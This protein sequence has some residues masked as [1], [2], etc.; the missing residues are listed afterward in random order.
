MTNQTMMRSRSIAKE[1]MLENRFMGTGLLV[2]LRDVT[3]HW[4]QPTP[5]IKTQVLLGIPTQVHH[6]FPGLTHYQC[7]QLV[8]CP[9]G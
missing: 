7:T 3:Q 6:R 5:K 9:K 8:S 1:A 4:Q 2:C